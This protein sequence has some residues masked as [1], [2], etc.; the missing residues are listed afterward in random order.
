[1]K[2]M[3]NIK[4]DK[5][6]KEKAQKVAKDLGLP[7]SVIFNNTLKKLVK[8]E[9]VVFQKSLVPNAKTRKILL[10]A[11]KDFKEGKRFS[12]IFTNVKDMEE[13]LMSL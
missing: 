12:P 7:M 9:R 2:T 3:M 6:L 1:M 13:Y 10:Q 11:S 8:E 4:V 5:E